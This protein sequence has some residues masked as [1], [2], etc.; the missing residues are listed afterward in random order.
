M[1]L[2]RG[3]AGAGNKR[4]FITDEWK[5]TLTAAKVKGA[6]WQELLSLRVA[7]A[8]AAGSQWDGAAYQAIRERRE[9]RGWEG[10]EDELAPSSSPLRNKDEVGEAVDDADHGTAGGKASGAAAQPE[11]AGSLG[12]WFDAADRERSEVAIAV[13]GYSAAVARRDINQAQ[14]AQG[15]MLRGLLW[16]QLAALELLS[17]EGK[18]TSA[19]CDM[20]SATEVLFRDIEAFLTMTTEHERQVETCAGRSLPFYHAH[21][22]LEQTELVWAA[23]VR[24]RESYRAACREG[25][26]DERGSCAGPP[27][28]EAASE[29]AAAVAASGR[30]LVGRRARGGN[31]ACAASRAQQPPERGSSYSEAAG[32]PHSG[33]ADTA[34]CAGLPPA[35]WPLLRGR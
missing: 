21:E 29:A 35:G 31:A 14:E 5:P 19:R 34:T 10:Q 15:R 23:V 11:E 13:N 28:L 1:D 6:T 26:I 2:G 22:A 9:D 20:A 16:S 27:W 8:R 4:S 30:S 18:W 12:V 32:G 17:E 3:A 24:A 25:G 7:R 33:A